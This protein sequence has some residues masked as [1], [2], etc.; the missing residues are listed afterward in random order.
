MAAHLK[1]REWFQTYTW[2]DAPA[3]IGLG[4]VNIGIFGAEPQPAIS[5]DGAVTVFFFGSLYNAEGLHQT[6]QKKGHAFPTGTDAE[7]ALHL[8][9]E[10]GEAVAA[11]I[12]GA[13][14]LCVWDARRGRLL[15]A[16]DRLGLIPHYY[17]HFG[18]RLVFAPQ[19]NGI[20][21]DAE[22]QRRLNLTSTAEFLRFQRLLGDK[23]FFEGMHL[24]PYGS[25]LI[26]QAGEDTLRVEH[27]WDFDRIPLWMASTEFE[28]AVIETGRL[29]RKA[30]EQRLTGDYRLGVYLSGGLDSRT[31]LGFASDRRPALPSVTYGHPRS[32]DVT[33]ARRV[34]RAV[35]SENHYFPQPDGRWLAQ[36]ADFHLAV[37]EGHTSF[38]HAHAAI[39]LEPAR[40][41][42]DVNLMGFNGDQI[43]GA[44]AIDHA[45]SAVNA[46]DDLAFL[47]HMYQ[48][49]TRDL[50]WPGPTEAEEK[51]LYT[52]AYYSQMRDRAFES[53]AVELQPYS[54]YPMHQRV[55]Y[56]TTIHQ[57]ARLSNLNAVYM[58]AF[59]EVRY[60]FCD[61]P[62]MD[63][64][65]SMPLAFRTHD[66][67]YLAVINREI[68]KVT[69]APRD[70]DDMLLTNHKLI[71]T[72]HGLYVRARRRI[73]HALNPRQTGQQLHGDP[74]DWLRDDLRDWA[75][76]ILFDQRTTERGI[77]NPAY[78]RSI[79][80]R[81]VSG[82]ELWTIGK[83][84]PLITFEMMLRRF[85]D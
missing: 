22:F 28:E 32:T 53:L 79:F 50:S 48:H 80:E 26:Y 72:A 31:I 9:E 4:Q 81:H 74:E 33:Y 23:T 5:A 18:G 46:P 47:A 61:Y 35:G 27:Y 30:V 13:F 19:V 56:F 36:H 8:Y 43:I 52:S 76:A 63:Y 29:L 39:S 16:N 73:S 34:A 25:T 77:F 6:L 20:L 66:R 14:N 62:L 51:L 55:D 24:L 49:L 68:P 75:A 7:L 70:T 2:I 41:W 64:V 71:R 42:L 83:I 1:L 3:G 69:W 59:I 67:L 15:L 78:L 38:I 84:A 11:A 60:P 44:R 45:A 40:Q 54:Q 58:R 85:F 37:T 10:Y 82:K 12:N 65:L 21:Q 17:A 57:G